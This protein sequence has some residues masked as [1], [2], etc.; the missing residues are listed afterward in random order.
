MPALVLGTH[1]LMN[2]PG[3]Q[4]G[5][6]YPDLL[7]YVINGHPERK[8]CS[9]QVSQLGNETDILTAV[10]GWLRSSRSP[11]CSST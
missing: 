7:F 4:G 10:S 6:C 5:N 8:S 9:F 3:G 11:L 1:Y 2:L